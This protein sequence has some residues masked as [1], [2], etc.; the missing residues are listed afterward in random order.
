MKRVRTTQTRKREHDT[1]HEREEQERDLDTR[2]FLGSETWQQALGARVESPPLDLRL[3]DP[4]RAV[5]ARMRRKALRCSLLREGKVDPRGV[6]QRVVVK[7]RASLSPVL[8]WIDVNDLGVRDGAML[9]VALNE[10]AWNATAKGTARLFHWNEAT[11]RLSLVRLSATGEDASYVWGW[12]SAPGRY[13]VVGLPANQRLLSVL[14]QLRVGLPLLKHAKHGQQSFKNNICEYILCAPDAIGRTLRGS[15]L[16]QLSSELVGGRWPVPPRGES[17]PGGSP[18]ELC[19]NLD[20]KLGLPELQIIKDIENTIVPWFVNTSLATWWFDV[21]PNHIG[22]VSI[23]VAVDQTNSRRVFA[24]AQFGGIWRLDW[25]ATYSQYIWTPLTDDAPTLAGGPLAIAPSNPNVIYYYDVRRVIRYSTNGG[26]SWKECAQLFDTV[27]RLEV[28][29]TDPNDLYIATMTGLWRW[30]VGQNAVLL[31]AGNITDVALDPDDPSIIYAAVRNVGID[32]YWPSAAGLTWST[33]FSLA[34]AQN[35][36]VGT[37]SS[38]M[39]NLALGRSGTSTTRTVAVKIGPRPVNGSGA[40]TSLSFSEVFLSRN[41]G[42]PGSWSRCNPMPETSFYNAGD[43]VNVIAVDPND[44]NVILVGTQLL[45]RTTDGGSQWAAVMQ[46]NYISFQHH[47]DQHRVTFDRDRPGV[48][49][50]ANDGGIFESRD[51]GATWQGI[52]NGYRT[53]PSFYIGAHQNSAMMNVNH[54]GVWGTADIVSGRWGMY[55]GPAWEYNPVRSD[56]NRPNTFFIYQTSLVRHVLSPDGSTQRSSWTTFETGAFAFSPDASSDLAIAVEVN[57]STAGDSNS[58][59]RTLSASN[60]TPTWTRELLTDAAGAAVT[61]LVGA[62][63]T[64]TVFAPSRPRAAY[65]IDITTG[66]IFYKDNV[67]AATAWVGRGNVAGTI[68]G[69]AVS[70]SDHDKVFVLTEAALWKSLD[71][72]NTFAQVAVTQGAPPSGTFRQFC[73]SPV[74]SWLYLRT[75]VSLY[76]SPNDGQSWFGFNDRLPNAQVYDI[77]LGGDFLCATLYGRGVWRRKIS[78]FSAIYP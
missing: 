74:D 76:V 4:G 9:V 34:D 75:D 7:L 20:V 29:P 31:H 68:V 62:K 3:F 73:C 78:G 54:W 60:A 11:R 32:R 61:Q 70:A 46:P 44:D 30:Q 25:D 63:L 53:L 47:E 50:V 77:S 64:G 58:L 41:A 42:N 48:V 23:D 38:E 19:L 66:R 69:L 51:H 59:R 52:N 49:Y 6:E 10:V 12:L 33:V 5:A 35:L 28:H 40:P 15:A 8:A 22:G 39:L 67:M 71:G 45:L 65:V 14:E 57:R 1:Q 27:S 43:W 18:C 55:E 16:Q 72:G 56:V 36:S 26:A 13:A 2:R 37:Y 17:S 24:I 21:S